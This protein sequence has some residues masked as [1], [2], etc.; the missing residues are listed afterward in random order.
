M[1]SEFDWSSA[2]PYQQQFDYAGRTDSQPVYIG[3]ATPGVATSDPKWKIRRFSYNSDGSVSQIQFA[4][5][6]V[7]FQ[8]IWDNRANAALITYK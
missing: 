1:W 7:G 3:W 6:D 5:G 4:N 8:Q 2:P